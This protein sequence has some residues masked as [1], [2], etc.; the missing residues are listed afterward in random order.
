MTLSLS[1]LVAI[2]MF[3]SLNA[4]SED[5]SLFT[6]PPWRNPWLLVAMSVS[7]GLH[8]LIL[9]VPFLADVFGIVPL[10]LNEWVLVILFSA[11]V[12]LIDEIL[13]F[14]K[15][16]APSSDPHVAASSFIGIRIVKPFEQ[17]WKKEVLNQL[18]AA[19]NQLLVS[20]I[21]ALVGQNGS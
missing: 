2:E 10:S 11:P 7:F 18:I 4:L 21:K 12:I 5:N 1:V 16:Q 20:G 6:M 8:C 3:N 17:Q 19:K 15:L 9:Y 13:K 14:V